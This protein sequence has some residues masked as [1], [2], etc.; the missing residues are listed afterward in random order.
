M[1]AG[2]RVTIPRRSSASSPVFRTGEGVEQLGWECR[3]VEMQNAAVGENELSGD[4][5]AAAP[6]KVNGLRSRV[7][8]D[9]E[10][11]GS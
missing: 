1:R 11:G 7:G 6:E 8:G 2:N 3:P 4:R 5:R 9:K 10:A